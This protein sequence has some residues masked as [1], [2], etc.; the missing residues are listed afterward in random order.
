MAFLELVFTLPKNERI[1]SF[2]RIAK[3][4]QKPI[5]EVELLLMRILNRKLIKGYIN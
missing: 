3:T 4:T 5:H 2:E 1:V